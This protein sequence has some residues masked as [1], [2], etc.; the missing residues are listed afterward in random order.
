VEHTQI[1]FTIEMDPLGNKTIDLQVT[2]GINYP[3]L[4]LKRAIIEYILAQEMEGKI[5]C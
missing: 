5:P 3:L 1:K 2:P 4:P